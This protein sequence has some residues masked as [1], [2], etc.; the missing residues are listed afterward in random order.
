MFFPVL[1]STHLQNERE[2][3]GHRRSR[4][5]AAQFDTHLPFE[6]W[7]DFFFNSVIFFLIV[8]VERERDK[9]FD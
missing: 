7:P 3:A 9:S 1:W 5:A 2:A 8:V 4:L 6:L